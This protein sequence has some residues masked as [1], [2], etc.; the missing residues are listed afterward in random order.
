MEQLL[1]ANRMTG[2]VKPF[3]CALFDIFPR[4][5]PLHG[6]SRTVSLNA[7]VTPECKAAAGFGPRQG[8]DQS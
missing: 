7:S 2:T 4:V 3:A 6:G 1:A 5:F 8:S